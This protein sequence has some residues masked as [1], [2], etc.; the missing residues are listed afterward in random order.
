GSS[1]LR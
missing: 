1:L